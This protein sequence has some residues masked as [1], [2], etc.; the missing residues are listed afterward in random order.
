MNCGDYGFQ[1]VGVMG[2]NGGGDGGW[3]WVLV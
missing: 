1:F 3:Q 2:G